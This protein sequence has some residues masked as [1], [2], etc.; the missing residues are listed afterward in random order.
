MKKI[1]VILLLLVLIAGA[2]FLYFRYLHVED[3]SKAYLRTVSAAMLGDETL[4]LDGFTETSRPL[5]A[6]LLALGRGLDPRRS[7]NHPYFYLV[8]ENVEA[9]EV[10]DDECWLILKRAGD[11]G[12][13]SAYDLRLVKVEGTWKID[14]LTFTG[15]RR[16]VDRAR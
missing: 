16:K 6:G 3:P 12:T 5:V 14:A 11:S 15:K 8:T 9:V 7:A 10:N 4:F 1:L 2:V 13:G